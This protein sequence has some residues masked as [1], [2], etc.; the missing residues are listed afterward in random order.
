M[1][2]GETPVRTL[3][4]GLVLMLT[5]PLLAL[6]VVPSEPATLFLAGLV[7][8]SLA[9]VIGARYRAVVAAAPEL[10]VG[11]RSHQHREVLAGL[12]APSH[13]NTA[14]RPRPRAPGRSGSVA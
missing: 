2:P 3:Y 9:A 13:P 12:A 5:G 10:T 7:V 6:I 1:R 8:L 4:A 11:H 14:G